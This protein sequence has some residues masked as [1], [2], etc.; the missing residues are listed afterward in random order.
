MKH[1]ATALILG[2]LLV[3]SA[4][5]ADDDSP[6]KMMKPNGEIDK[7]QCEVC[8]EADNSLSRGKLDSCTICHESTVHG[9]SAQH[10][11]ATA[12][13]VAA[14]APK[15]S[16]KLPLAEDGTIYCGTCHVF[17]DPR[18]VPGE[19]LLSDDWLPAATGLAGRVR[20]S[21]EK[22]FAEVRE[23]HADKNAV[24]HFATRPVRALRLSVSDGAL[25]RHCHGDMR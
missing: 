11:A 23:R 25:C 9:G 8:H 24:A 16:P 3:V 7:K 2:A 15:S 17:H 14:L 19:S 22:Q 18:A 4:A 12:E 10:L 5:R 13:R 6:H 1:R 21:V 20:Q